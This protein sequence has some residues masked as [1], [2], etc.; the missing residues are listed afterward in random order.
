MPVTHVSPPHQTPLY[1]DYVVDSVPDCV[2]YQC[3]TYDHVQGVDVAQWPEIVVLL[4]YI[5]FLLMGVGYFMYCGFQPQVSRA[6]VKLDPSESDPDSI[7]ESDH[8]F[9]SDEKSTG[10]TSDTPDP[11]ESDP[12]ESKEA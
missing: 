5:G 2:R 10:A 9:F 4:T 3:H 7:S 11:S 6:N 8:D 12:D 1:P